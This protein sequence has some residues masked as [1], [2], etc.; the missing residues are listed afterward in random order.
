MRRR[1]VPP[2]KIAACSYQQTC[3]S[4]PTLIYPCAHRCLLRRSLRDTVLQRDS[5]CKGARALASRSALPL[6]LLGP[7]SLC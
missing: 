1:A 7:F 4:L 3:A 2:H 6:A 5:E